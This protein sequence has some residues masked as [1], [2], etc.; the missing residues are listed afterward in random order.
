MAIVG[1]SWLCCYLVGALPFGYLIGRVRGVNLFQ[2]GSGNIGATNAGRVLGRKFGILI[3]VLDFLKGAIPVAFINHILEPHTDIGLSPAS[4]RVGA[5]ASVF[6]GHLFPIYLGFR[7]GKGVATG[8]GAVAVLM[9]LPTLCAFGTWV[10]CLFGWRMVSLAS[11]AAVVAL[12]LCRVA[13]TAHPFGKLELVTTAF[14]FI[15]SLFVVVKHRANIRRIRN[16][17]ETRIGDFAMRAIA[18][19]SL[20]VLAIGFWFGGAGFFNFVAARSLFPSFEAV[21]ASSPS[22]RTAFIPIV[23]PGT[24]DDAKKK[25]ASALAGAAVGP[26]FPQYYAMQLIC[27]T[28]GLITA[29]SWWNAEPTTR[30]H[31]R[32]VTVIGLALLTVI[33]GWWVS[34]IVGELRLARFDPDPI[35]AKVASDAFTIWHFVSLGLS[36]VAV[37]LSGVALAMAGRMP[38]APAAPAA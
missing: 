10:V 17:T 30:V 7:G 29:I 20:H 18:V 1:L 22:D 25:L 28:I 35:A 32:R 5:A 4:I 2:V 12:S 33:V 37:L 8:A 36:M 6:L 38:N 9:P 15:G 24:S 19:R 21:V 3:F 31:R 11:I 34:S 26:I 23:P 13:F 16:G 27:G 14:C